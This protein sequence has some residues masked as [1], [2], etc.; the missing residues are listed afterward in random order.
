MPHVAIEHVIMIPILLLQVFIFPVVANHL[1]NTWIVSRR[2]LMLQDIASSMGSSI[3]QMYFAINH[4]TT[5]PSGTTTNQFGLPGY[6][7]GYSYTA[8]A[9]LNPSQS[10]S[11]PTQLLNITVRLTTTTIVVA[12]QVLLGSEAKWN[13]TT[14]F[15]SNS[16]TAGAYAIKYGNGTISLGFGG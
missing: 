16:T 14:I 15:Q 7:D 8:N 10:M 4:N 2:T 9:T 13:S 5:I 6:I 11:N 12:S 1:M 3:Q